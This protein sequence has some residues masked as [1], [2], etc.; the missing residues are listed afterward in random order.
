MNPTKYK[1]YVED[2][3]TDSS[4]DLTELEDYDTWLE[5]EKEG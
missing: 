2:C 3:L 4:F 5:S 1:V